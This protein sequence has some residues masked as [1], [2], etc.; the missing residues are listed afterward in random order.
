MIAT[1][2]AVVVALG[3]AA[4]FLA[5][6]AGSNAGLQNAAAVG[7]LVLSAAGFVALLRYVI[8]TTEIARRS[9]E[10]T[11]IASQMEAAKLNFELNRT[12][13]T[14]NDLRGTMSTKDGLSFSDQAYQVAAMIMN[15]LEIAW[16]QRDAH[17]LVPGSWTLYSELLKEALKLPAVRT[18]W[19]SSKDAYHQGFRDVVA[20]S[21]PQG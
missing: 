19:V 16:I 9:A 2:S 20:N 12:L 21:W 11:R 14:I 18:Y 4:F 10:A 1:I 6:Q 8:D 17:D 15:F 3:G 5:L 13:L 7:S